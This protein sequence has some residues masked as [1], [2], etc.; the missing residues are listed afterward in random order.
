MGS[1]PSSRFPPCTISGV[2]PSPLATEAHIRSLNEK[3][4]GFLNNWPQIHFCF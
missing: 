4:S 2:L 1:L 3:I